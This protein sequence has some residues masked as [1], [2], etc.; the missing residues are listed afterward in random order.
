MSNA[1]R[2]LVWI[3]IAGITASI[4]VLAKQVSEGSLSPAARL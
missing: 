3:V 2:V 4:I 1:S